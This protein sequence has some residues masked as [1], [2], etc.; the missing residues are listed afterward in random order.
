M[1]VKRRLEVKSDQ[2]GVCIYDDF[3]HH[4]TA[5]TKTTHALKGSA[6]HKRVLAVLEFGSHTMR[7]GVHHEALVHAFDE[8]DGAYFLKPE[9]SLENLASQWQFPYKI[10]DTTTDI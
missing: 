8:V 10:C 3:A 6:R 4:P 7:M 5:I 1:P 2:H 9:F